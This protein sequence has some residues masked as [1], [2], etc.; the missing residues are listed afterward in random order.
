MNWVDDQPWIYCLEDSY[1]FLFFFFSSFSLF[2]WPLLFL[3]EYSKT[4]SAL[5]R[6]PNGKQRGKFA[7]KRNRH[8]ELKPAF[9]PSARESA[10]FIVSL[11]QLKDRY[12]REMSN[13]LTVTSRDE[14]H[15]RHTQPTEANLSAKW[16][17]IHMFFT[18]IFAPILKLKV[19]ITSIFSVKYFSRGNLIAKAFLDR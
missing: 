17:A 4:Y 5:F 15:F 3:N 6:P 7:G 16:N 18:S 1:F 19:Q 8:N 9:N 14:T 13:V 2:Y 12:F 10:K 11:P